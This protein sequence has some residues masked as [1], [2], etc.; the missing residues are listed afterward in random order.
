[1]LYEVITVGIPRAQELDFQG[2]YRIAVDGKLTLLVDDFSKP[3]GLCF[4]RDEKTLYINDTDHQHIRAFTVADDGTLTDGRLWAELYGKERGV[5]DGMKLDS[6]GYLYC[7]GVITSYS[8]HYTKLYE[9]RVNRDH[10]RP[11]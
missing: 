6:N 1:M 4:S 7:S 2:V 10:R 9:Y 5:A 11:R 3:N 8:I